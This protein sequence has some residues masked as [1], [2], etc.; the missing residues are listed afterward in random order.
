[1]LRPPESLS[2]HQ[3]KYK[4]PYPPAAAPAELWIPQRFGKGPAGGDGGS[5]LS[6]VV[7]PVPP[8]DAQQATDEVAA[9]AGGAVAGAAI[10][11]V[12]YGQQLL[13]Q[14]QYQ[15]P[16]LPA[17]ATTGRMQHGMQQG[18]QL[19]AAVQQ[20]LTVVYEYGRRLVQLE[21]QE[22]AWRRQRRW[23]QRPQ[24]G[25]WQVRGDVSVVRQTSCLFMY[26]LTVFHGF[27]GFV[28]YSP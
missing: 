22:A 25:T 24:S 26:L 21:E 19:V 8:P 28:R 10:V 18:P 17:T 15:V 20:L 23:R 14:Q 13:P 6:E 2:N 7:A 16:P 27:H 1:M 11:G 5:R 4:Y 3:Y 12:G 9:A